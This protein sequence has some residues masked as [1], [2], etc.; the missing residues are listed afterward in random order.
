MHLLLIQGYLL[1]VNDKVPLIS[2][3]QV[4]VY[5]SSYSNDGTALK[6]AVIFASSSK[7]NVGLKLAV[8]N[9]FVRKNSPPEPKMLKDNITTGAIVGSLTTLDN[10]T[11]LP[12]IA[13]FSDISGKADDN[14]FE[15]I[16]KHCQ[17]DNK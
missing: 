9:E 10:K 12:V 8:D 15:M 5:P 17:D 16:S 2:T 1:I 13:E 14:M 11:S 4:A 7:T 6:P 3:E